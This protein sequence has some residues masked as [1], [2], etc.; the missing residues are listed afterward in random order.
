M[1][2]LERVETIEGETAYFEWNNRARH[3]TRSLSRAGELADALSL[4][5][6]DQ[7]PK[8]GVVG[9]KGKGTTTAYASAFLHRAGLKVGTVLSP[10]LSSDR[11]R[12]RVNGVDLPE[13]EYT[14]LL[15]EVGSARGSIPKRAVPG[16]LSP[17][18]FF[19]LAGIFH[20]Q[21]VGCDVAVVEAGMGGA[22]DELSLFELQGVAMSQVF[23]EHP[24]ILGNTRELIAE[25][26]IAV[27]TERTRFINYLA[28]SSEVERV[29]QAR[30]TRFGVPAFR[31]D[32]PQDHLC[33]LPPGLNAQNAVLGLESGRALYKYGNLGDVNQPAPAITNE[34]VQYP[35]RLSRHIYRTSK[36]IV[37]SSVN[38][39]GLVA[40]LTYATEVFEEI[41]RLILVSIPENKDYVGFKEE[42]R[43]FPSRVVFV[44]MEN[45]HLPFP[46]P[47]TWERE[48]ATSSQLADLLGQ[49]DTVLVVGT[50]T[51]S[52]AA[53]KIAGVD[54]TR[55]F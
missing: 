10:G 20:F 11:D 30:A 13:D 47:Q 14:D 34:D 42:L 1:S 28:Q 16:Y 24:E 21:R 37:D 4:R 54:T 50:V 18:G 36:I 40:A 26:K 35:G 32:A 41:P 53:L 12:I 2:D 39:D 52:A 48:W 29:I 51:F 55:I 44:C 33:K 15:S 8:L 38:R 19:M 3:E 5:S 49:A 9:S 27:A 46:S 43:D 22:S 23:I 31:I 17:S 45:S 6:S 7:L 25:N